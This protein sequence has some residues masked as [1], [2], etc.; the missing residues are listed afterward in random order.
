MSGLFVKIDAEY[1]SDDE[2][3]E[4]GPMAELL[5][6]RG[7]CFCK[8]K[9]LDGTISRAQLDIVAGKIPSAAKHAAKLV[10]VGL[11]E[12]TDD[13][14]LILSWLKW[15]K[16]AAEI[17][18][19]KEA[20]RRASVEANHAQHHVGV[21]KR[22]SPKCEI[23]RAEQPPPTAPKSAPKSENDRTRNR[24]QEV[25]GEVEPQGE[26]EGEVEKIPPQDNYV[27][28][29]EAEGIE[30]VITNLAKRMRYSA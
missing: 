21:G 12:L 25:E 19:D 16:S 26:A 13:G 20:R 9:R 3:I 27:P 7:C 17:V 6:I 5:F 22:T 24:L 4:A 28:P 18:D 11:W 14:W 15:N 23:C 29:D 10:E 8:R 2:F 1:P 30:A